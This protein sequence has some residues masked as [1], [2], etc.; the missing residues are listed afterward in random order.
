MDA[1]YRALRESR[2]LEGDEL[3]GE[4]SSARRSIAGAE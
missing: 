2:Q 1:F 4:S 3:G